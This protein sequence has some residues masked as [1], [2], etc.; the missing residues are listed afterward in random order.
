MK[1]NV[2]LVNVHSDFYAP[3]RPL[4]GRGGVLYGM[5]FWSPAH[6]ALVCRLPEAEWSTIKHKDVL[7]TAG[8]IGNVWAVEDEFV[9]E[10]GTCFSLLSEAMAHEGVAPKT[11]IVPS[12]IVKS[13]VAISREEIEHAGA[14]RLR[15]L[16]AAAQLPS[17]R[18]MTKADDLRP[19]LLAFCGHAEAPKTAEAS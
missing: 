1:K 14:E 4:Q 9:C 12:G 5:A 7:S 6:H 13:G 8:N 17:F 19:A 10:D 16:A 11:N 15:H 2:L 18:K 3:P